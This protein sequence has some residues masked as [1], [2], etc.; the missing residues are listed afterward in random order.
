MSQRLQHQRSE[1]GRGIH[2]TS[3]DSDISNISITDNKLVGNKTED[4]QKVNKYITEN[5]YRNNK[6]GRPLLEIYAKREKKY[7]DRKIWRKDHADGEI[8]LN[9]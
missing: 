4:R 5:G 8:T 2:W 9:I 6:C 7:F 3:K 1:K